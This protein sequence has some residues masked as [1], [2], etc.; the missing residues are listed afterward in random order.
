MSTGSA[1]KKA[2][3]ETTEPSV[4][5]AKDLKEM[6]RKMINRGVKSRRRDAILN[7]ARAEGKA[8]TDID[9][10]SKGVDY[11]AYLGAGGAF[12][13]SFSQPVDWGDNTQT[14]ALNS[15]GVMQS[16]N[17]QIA[18]NDIGLLDHTG[19]FAW[20]VLQS[21]MLLDS[22]YADIA[23]STGNL[24]STNLGDMLSTPSVFNSGWALSYGF[25]DSGSGIGGLTNQDQ[26]YV[27]VTPDSSTWMGN[28]AN[29]MGTSL[30]SQPFSV[31]ALPGAHDSGMFDTTCVAQIVKN[32]TFLSMLAP[33]IG[34]ELSLL[35][36]LS[37]SSILRSV[38]NL[39]FTQKDDITSMLNLGVR[40]FDVR[41]GYCYQGIATG[42]YH[43]HNF[44]PGYPYQSFLEDVLTWLSAHPTE[45]V[46]VSANFQGFASPDMQPSL[47]EL[48]VVLTTAQQATNTQQTIVPGDKNDLSTSYSGL[49]AANKRLIFLNQV[50]ASDDAS[51]YDSYTDAYQTTNVN[52]ILQALAGM[53]KSG[54]A[55]HDYTVLQLQGTAS[56]IG[57]GI[58][59]SIVTLSD[60]SSPLMSTK[61]G[62]DN[63]TYPWL[64]NNVPAN[65]SAG[66]LVVFLNDFCDNALAAY[67]AGLT[68]VR[69]NSLA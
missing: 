20:D 35:M 26:S 11:Y 18:E 44:I 43:Q 1:P 51:K 46:V 16:G 60:A 64:Q 10:P 63:Q 62:F 54:Q 57:G 37:S 32:T 68:Q 9:W 4:R 2:A 33:V 48:A 27:Y 28:L 21:G 7:A 65:L 40:Y 50:G 67:A 41:P 61:P 45:I 34:W 39:A 59:D 5:P 19:Q 56:G 69:A 31:F 15:P 47:A 58:F 14:Y 55:G 42:I 13:S 52:V 29:A 6:T 66:Q 36:L 23:P 53:N 3:I 22:A 17:L 49:L 24:G 30:T 38:I 8:V 25:Y 12:G